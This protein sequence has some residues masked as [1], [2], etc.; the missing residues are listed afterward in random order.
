[1]ESKILFF[2]VALGALLVVAGSAEAKKK[3]KTA[4]EPSHIY[5]QPECTGKKTMHWDDATQ[6]CQKNK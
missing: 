3:A 4:A 2:V 5:T 1:M 6:T